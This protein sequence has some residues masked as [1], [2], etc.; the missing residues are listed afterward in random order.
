MTE[1]LSAMLRTATPILLAALGGVLCEKAGVLNLALE[2]MMLLGAFFGVV[3]SYYT[4]SPYYGILI[5]LIIGAVMGMLYYVFVEHWHT[6]AMITS[7]GINMLAAGFTSFMKR[8]LFGDSGMIIGINGIP[9]YSSPFLASIPVIGKI[10]NGHA[11]T[12]YVSILLVI[13]LQI[14]LYRTHTG[15]NLRAVGEKPIAATSAGISVQKYRFLALTVGGLLCGLAGAHLSLGYV[16]MF[17]EDMTGGRGFFAFTCVAFGQANPLL[18]MLASFVFGLAENISYFIQDLSIPSQFILMTPY[19]CT[20]LA[21]ILRTVD[22]KKIIAASRGRRMSKKR[23]DQ[24]LSEK[25]L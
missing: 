13:L 2:G 21:L 14:F 24:P 20:I 8:Y 12:V 7:I 16:N 17:A 25:D 18:V 10:L 11:Y 6:D 1:I 23:I 9:K 15:I 5:A 19:V 4:L 22:L 3:G